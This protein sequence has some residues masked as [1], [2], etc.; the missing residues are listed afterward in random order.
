[1]VGV[2]KTADPGVTQ[3]FYAQRY[4]WGCPPE[5]RIRRCMELFKRIRGDRLLDVGCGG[6][7]VTVALKDAMDAK[8]AFGVEIAPEGGA[9]A[10]Q[11][12]IRA[13]QLDIDQH[14]LPFEDDLFDAAYW[15]E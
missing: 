15:G 4:N 7:A 5:E 9:A 11:R 2:G 3:R 10:K 6:G 13:E 12:G 1:M 8:E 14:D